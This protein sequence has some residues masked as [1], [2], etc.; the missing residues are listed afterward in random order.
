MKKLV[1]IRMHKQQVQE[2]QFAAVQERLAMLDDGLAAVEV[3]LAETR[4]AELWFQVKV[5]EQWLP[6]I[7]AQLG[8]LWKKVAGMGRPMS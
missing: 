6:V 1:T 3:C 2:E 4:E 5:V 8:L 7:A